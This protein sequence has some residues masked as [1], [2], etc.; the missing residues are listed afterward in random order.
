M[1]SLDLAFIASHLDTP[2]LPSTPTLSELEVDNET[3]VKRVPRLSY[4]TMVGTLH[5]PSI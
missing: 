1:A 4:D 5:D 3:M 2:R